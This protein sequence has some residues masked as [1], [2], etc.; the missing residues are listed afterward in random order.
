VDNGVATMWT[1]DCRGIFECDG[2]QN[3]T[4]SI[5]GGHWL[6]CP[7][8]PPVRV[9]FFFFFSFSG[10]ALV[11]LIDTY[12]DRDAAVLRIELHKDYLEAR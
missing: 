5:D 8:G 2:K 4:C 6:E 11:A 9:L 7:C 10:Q 1:S 12:S 3:I